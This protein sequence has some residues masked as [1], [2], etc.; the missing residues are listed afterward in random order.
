L[1]SASA[2]IQSI[3]PDDAGALVH[4]A[5]VGLNGRTDS[6]RQLTESGDKLAST[7]AARTDALDRLAK[8]G[9]SLTNEVAN[10]RE[11]LGQSLTDLRQV[12]DALRNAK[13]DTT[14]SLDRGS[15]LLT[16][17]GDLVAGQKKN[18]D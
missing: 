3:N 17:V 8:N 2:L 16:Q 4:E 9:T 13:G 11:A 10:H 15:Q 12:A 6:L 14:L 1:R 18:L 5:A 7:F